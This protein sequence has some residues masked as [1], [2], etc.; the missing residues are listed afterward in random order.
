MPGLAF[1]QNTPPV[2][3]SVSV[4][5]VP[6]PSNTPVTIACSAHDTDGTIVRMRVTVGGGTLPAGGTAQ[7]VTITSGSSVSGTITWN[8]PGP[9]SYTVRCAVQDD[10]GL[11]VPAVGSRTI[12]VPVTVPVGSPPVVDSLSVSHEPMLVGA[13]VRLTAIAHDPDGDPITYTWSVTGG[14]LVPNGASADWTAPAAPGG[15]TI[16]VTAKDPS[17]GTGVR[18][19]TVG[20]VIKL[21]EGSLEAPMTAPRRVAASPAGDLYVVDGAG[22]RLWFLTPRGQLKGSPDLGESAAAVVFCSGTLWVSTVS[23]KIL[24]VDPENGRVLRELPIAGGPL[25]GG[26]GLAC[27]AAAGLLFAAE[28]QADRVR[29]FR[30]DGSVAFE[31]RDAGGVRLELPVDVAVDES[32]G[33]LWVVVESV[34]YG[35]HA[36]A[37]GLD[38]TYALS[39]APYGSGPGKLSRSG[40]VTA[41][42]GK[43]Y[44][45]DIFQGVVQAFDFAGNPLGE[46]GTFGDL[47]GQMR[48][49]MGLVTTSANELVVA[50]CDFGRL[51]R[52][53]LGEPL[54]TCVGDLDCD[55]LPD[56]WE[57]AYGL[58]PRDPRDAMADPDGDGLRNLTELA[59]GTNP[60]NPDTDGDGYSDGTE[61]AEGYDPLDPV[62]HGLRLVAGPPSV[63]DPGLLSMYVTVSGSG[64]APCAVDWT[65]VEGP[66]VSLLGNG[67]SSASFVARYAG[68]YRFRA[69]ATCGSLVSKPV[70]VEAT[71]RN[72][73]PRPDPGRIAVV[74]LGDKLRLDGS[75]SSDANGDSLGLN[76][77]QVG[78]P[79]RLGS[80]MGPNALLNANQEGLFLFELTARDPQGLSAAATVPVLVTSGQRLFPTAVAVTPVFG[81]VGQTVSLDASGSSGPP[82]ALKM[83]HWLQVSGP[84]V[85][86]AAG[87]TGTPSFVPAKA[88]KYVFQVSL[89]D[90]SLVSPPDTVEVFVAEAGGGRPIAVVVSS[91]AGVV[92][93]PLRLDARGSTP[94]QAGASL[95]YSWRQ[96]SGP[97]AGLKDSDSSVATAVPFRPGSH[98]F[99]LTVKEGSV[100]GVPAFVRIDADAPGLARP[101][102]QATGPSVARTNR[103]IVLDGSTSSDADGH[104]LH[105]RWTQVA[106]PWVVLRQA[107][108]SMP[109]FEAPVPGLYGFELEVDDGAIRSAPASIAV[110]VFSEGAGTP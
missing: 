74:S 58:N 45:S 103:Q 65:Q 81:E 83:F 52:F 96:V 19:L 54:R 22:G 29:A 105:Y 39:M 3:D 37:F 76:W 86:L 27:G 26:A 71:V 21:Y 60:R 51:E 91:L 15:Q 75:F 89:E 64:G 108:T 77:V 109:R 62:D 47:P 2:V 5:P 18:A 42:G 50:N 43:V 63:G 44:I 102:A 48:H 10:G 73:A 24:N 33:T 49:P 7:D 59:R 101:I 35:V 92:G 93:E 17:G 41:A 107:D 4:L 104:A 69:V 57:L 87:Q 46:I 36:H 13:T 56:A 67:D 20:V 66:G 25:Q 110:L 98:V 88:G 30:A 95:V 82:V 99:E 72:V 97:A 12:T 100:E 38:G 28:R 1:A 9:G 32:R 11:G 55:G 70:G 106:G 90:G 6:T 16:T 53:G 94:S 79:G 85:T 31:L 40:G 14:T 80:S 84:S 34:P 78:G 8:T 61:V 23:G 68:K